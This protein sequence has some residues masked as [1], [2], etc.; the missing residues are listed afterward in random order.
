MQTLASSFKT[1]GGTT[2]QFPSRAESVSFL[3]FLKADLA[4]SFSPAENVYHQRD[5]VSHFLASP[6]DVEQVR[7]ATIPWRVHSFFRLLLQL[8][9]FGFLVCVDSFLFYFTFLPM[10]ILLLVYKQILSLLWCKM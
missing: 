3:R 9:L 4:G 8:I 2:R 10:R 6:L 5:R 1:P 7:L